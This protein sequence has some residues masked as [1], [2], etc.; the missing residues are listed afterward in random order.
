[1]QAD[2]YDVTPPATVDALRDAVLK[3]NAQTYGQEANVAA[4]V[5]ADTI[6][7]TQSVICVP[8]KSCWAMRPCPRPKPIPASMLPI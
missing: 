3:G 5:D 1:M 4:H 2:G 6:V 7:R 8:F